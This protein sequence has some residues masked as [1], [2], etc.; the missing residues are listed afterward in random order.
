MD[1][2]CIRMVRKVAD[3]SKH[4]LIIR[5][6]IVKLQRS[7]YHTHKKKKSNLHLPSR[8]LRSWIREYGNVRQVRI[9]R[10]RFSI[11]ERIDWRFPWL[12]S[13]FA[14]VPT[15]EEIWAP[16]QFDF[17]CDVYPMQNRWKRL[18]KL[19]CLLQFLSFLDAT[20]V[21]FTTGTLPVLDLD[22]RGQT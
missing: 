6:T 15:F 13:S 17:R 10:M 20:G 2:F 16:K 18:G 14:V 4:Y 3:L 5:I 21:F 7:Y 22:F 19:L 12:V 9:L 8:D 11:C 1:F